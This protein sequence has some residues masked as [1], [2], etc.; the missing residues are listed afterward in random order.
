MNRG[1]LGASN[2]RI[3]TSLARAWA[4][5]GVLSGNCLIGWQAGLN[6]QQTQNTTAGTGT[7]G[8]STFIG[9]QAGS[10]VT[11]GDSNVAV[12]YQAAASLTTGYSNV[13]VGYQAG[14]PRAARR[15]SASAPAP[16]W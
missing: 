9:Y 1:T 5:P 3:D 10:G 4:D 2:E 15:T 12:G 13:S 7:G 8:F 6:V 11:T 14:R 16:A